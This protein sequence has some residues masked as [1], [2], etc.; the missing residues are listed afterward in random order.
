[1]D[2]HRGADL[3]DQASPAPRP[4]SHGNQSPLDLVVCC[5]YRV[6]GDHSGGR[7]SHEGAIDIPDV[8]EIITRVMEGGE[9]AFRLRTAKYG[10]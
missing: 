7:I 1:M 6:A 9:T 8:R 2:V 10:F 4:G 5:Q 3:R